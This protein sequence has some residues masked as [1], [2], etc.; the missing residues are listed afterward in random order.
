MAKTTGRSHSRPRTRSRSALSTPSVP[1]TCRPPDQ[2]QHGWFEDC[3]HA[4]WLSD[5]RYM[6]LLRPLV[7]HQTQ[8]N[9]IW[10]A[11]AGTVTDG[12]SIPQVFWSVIGGPFEDKYRDGAVNHD[13][14][15]C[16]QRNCWHEVHR[17]F[18]DAMLARDVERWRAR[19][20]YF[21]VYFF[22]PRWPTA[23]EKRPRRGFTEDDIARAADLFKTR[24]GVEPDRIETLTREDLRHHSARVPLHIPGAALLRVGSRIRPVTRKAPC[25]TSECN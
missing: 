6:A 5:G 7:F 3:V 15:C 1:G 2:R 16:V 14:E 24:A 8:G 13:Y 18:Y 4:C 12:A 17:M 25:T 20:M 9:R 21:A 22:G 11:P 10:T 19:L 23:T